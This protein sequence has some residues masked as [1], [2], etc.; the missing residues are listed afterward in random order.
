MPAS[1]SIVIP[2]L[3]RGDILL[4]TLRSLQ[5]LAVPGA[6]TIVVDQTDR[7]PES[8]ASRL[9]AWSREGAL[10]WIRLDEPSI[11]H[12]MNVGLRAARSPV[13]LFLDDDIVPSD[14]LL[15][16]HARGH[17]ADDGVWAVA[18]Q[19]LQPGEAP[20]VWTGGA[21]GDGLV[22]DLEFPFWSTDRVWVSNVMAGNLSV[23]RE[24]AVQVGGFDENFEGVAH[25]FETEFC[26]RL[27]NAGGRVL[28]EPAASI[29]HLRVP[30]GGTRSA[31]GHLTSAA[32][33][34][35]MGDYY[36]ALRSGLDL[37]AIKHILRRPLREVS[38]R[39]HLRHPWYVPVKLTGELRAFG[40]AVRAIRRGPRLLRVEDEADGQGSIAS[41]R[42][43]G[44]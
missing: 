22:A 3:G 10:R 37:A 7:P 1:I 19:V 8:V 6:E 26:R 5:S 21:R 12:A 33:T 32:P 24:R 17:A 43:G 28:F 34:H 13:V 11:P 36:F 41:S 35:G 42:T 14:D 29:R 30:H 2:T 16:A 4:D 9:Q 18:G 25:R 38:T 20:R 40:A 23:R 39:F 27:I 15:A 31:G 44:V